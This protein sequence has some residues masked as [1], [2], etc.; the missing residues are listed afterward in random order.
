[1]LEDRDEEEQHPDEREDREGQN[2]ERV[3]H[4]PLHAA[5]DLHLLLDLDRD[6]VE[7]RVQDPGCLARLDHRDVEA[8]E[9]VRVSRHRLRQQHSALDIRA[10][11]AEDSCEGLVVGLLLED[12]E[13]CDDVEPGV[14]HRRELPREDLQ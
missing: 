2:D 11:L 12:D 14:D 10:N 1:M 4:R 3:D 9:G 13:R 7:D 8:V 5:A 6:A